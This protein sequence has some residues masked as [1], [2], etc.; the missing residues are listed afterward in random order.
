MKRTDLIALAELLAEGIV[1]GD[2]AQRLADFLRQIA[3]SQPVAYAIGDA[4]DVGRGFCWHRPE[5]YGYDPEGFR[6]LYTLPLED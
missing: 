1:T 4:D 5:E 2:E 3:E 6:P